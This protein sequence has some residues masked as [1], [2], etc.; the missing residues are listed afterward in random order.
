[1]MKEVVDTGNSVTY[2]KSSLK[3]FLFKTHFYELP[4]ITKGDVERMWT[5]DIKGIIQDKKDYLTLD[6]ADDVDYINKN[7]D[8]ANKAIN[9]LKVAYREYKSQGI[10]FDPKDQS[11]DLMTI[12]RLE[13]KNINRYKHRKAVEIELNF[14]TDIAENASYNEKEGSKAVVRQKDGKLVAAKN[15][16]S[17]TK[18]MMVNML[19][20]RFY[21]IGNKQ[22]IKLGKYDLNKAVGF[23]NSSS[24]FLTLSLNIASGTANVINANAQ[25]FLETFLKGHTFTAKDIAKAQ[26]IYGASMLDTIS[27][28]TNPINNSFPNQVMEMFNTRGLYNLSNANFLQSSIAKAGFQLS[29]LQVLQDSG[30]HWIQSVITMAVLNNIKV[31]NAQNR[32]IDVDGKI[33]EA[34][35]AA[36]LLDMLKRDKDTGLVE[37]DPKVVYTSHNRAT[38]WNEGGKTKIDTLIRKKLYDSLGNYTETDQPEVFRHWLGKLGMLYRKYLVPMG[39]ARMRGLEH[40]FTKKEDLNDYDRTFSYALQEYEEGTYTTLVR[41]IKTVLTGKKGE[42]LSMHNWDNL[43]E[44]E[45]HNIKRSVTEIVMTMVVLP[46][47]VMFVQALA[48]AGDDDDDF[49]FFIAYQLRRLETELSAYRDPR[50]SFKMLRSPIPSARLIES[51]MGLVGSLFTPWDWDETYVSGTNK[52]RN[53]LKVKFY[54]QIPVIKEFQRK[55]QDLFE[56]QNSKFGI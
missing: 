21:D 26:K 3:K 44:Y 50:E 24:A 41:H 16:N 23:I 25:M 13:Y 47:A 4:K 37:V 19:E 29:S 28:V 31:K 56:Y 33:V 11:M 22:Q 53:K 32:Y 6:R 8:L 17:N 2:G 7:V 55:Y 43:T 49:L 39:Q 52:D 46:M 9:T 54:K 14:L 34:K 10:V 40:S 48:E 35:E 42:L 1:M 45:K 18:Q 20:S 12:F 5:G 38:R 36:S 15:T 51:A 27:D 30:E